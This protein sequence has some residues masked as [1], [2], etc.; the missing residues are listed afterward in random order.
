MVVTISSNS[1]HECLSA[2]FV[3]YSQ[4]LAWAFASPYITC[5]H[6]DVF[7]VVIFKSVV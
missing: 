2:R 1:N 6:I 4:V 7:V 5:P 3:G